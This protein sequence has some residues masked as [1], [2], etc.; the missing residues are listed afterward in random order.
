M[1]TSNI[2]QIIKH[3]PRLN[4]C[5]ADNLIKSNSHCVKPTIFMS[6]ALYLFHFISTFTRVQQPSLPLPKCDR[7]P[8]VHCKTITVTCCYQTVTCSV[9]CSF[10]YHFLSLLN[11]PPELNFPRHA[12]ISHKDICPS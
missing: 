7:M 9:Q 10:W 4:P 2:A 3:I 6:R 5:C 12:K 8:L 1:C 11:F